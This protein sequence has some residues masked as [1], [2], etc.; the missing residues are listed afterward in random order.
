[1]GGQYIEPMLRL[2]WS[3]SLAARVPGPCEICRRWDA[4]ALCRDCIARYAAPAP[5]CARCGLRLGRPAAACGGCLADPPPYEHTLVAIDYTFPWDR[6]IAAF[7]FHGRVEL[8]GAFASRIVAAALATSMPAPQLVLPVPLSPQRLAARGYNQAWELA[9]RVAAAV[10]APADA[11]LLLRVTDTAQQTEL[12]RAARLHNLRSAF[13]VDAR[14]R[15][16]L[17]GLR[18]ALIDDVITTGATAR[19]AAA[20]LLRAGATAVDAWALARTPEH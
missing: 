15:G 11:Q 16:S 6:L 19:Q 8:A 14:R 17:Q 3:S 5:R 9:R 1:M 12:G 13:M 2:A 7:K 18:V 4:G 10:A 20:V